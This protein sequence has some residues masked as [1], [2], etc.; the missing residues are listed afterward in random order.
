M[1]FERQVPEYTPFL[2][3]VTR[4]GLARRPPQEQCSGQTSDSPN[5]C[6]GTRCIFL[7][8]LTGAHP[9]GGFSGRRLNLATGT[10]ATLIDGP[11]GMFDGSLG[12]W[13]FSQRGL[14]GPIKIQNER[15]VWRNG[16]QVK[17]LNKAR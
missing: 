5:H 3:L 7:A 13:E 10:G 6:V 8:R 16:G 2:L 15:G 9:K 12:N 17:E 4:C 11:M 1:C 14:G